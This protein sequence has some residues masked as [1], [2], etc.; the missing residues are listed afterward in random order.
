MTALT[1]NARRDSSILLYDNPTAPRSTLSPSIP[2]EPPEPLLHTEIS[3][4]DLSSN[5]GNNNTNNG[6]TTRS[7]PPPIQTTTLKS[8]QKHSPSFGFFIGSRDKSGGG[9]AESTMTDHPWIPFRS[10]Q[11]LVVECYANV[12]AVLKDVG[13]P[14][15]KLMRCMEDIKDSLLFRH[16]DI[17]AHHGA[18]IEGEPV[19]AYSMTPK[20]VRFDD[21]NYDGTTPLSPVYNRANEVATLRRGV[22]RYHEALWGLNDAAKRMRRKKGWIGASAGRKRRELVELF[23]EVQ[24][25]WSDVMMCLAI[26][27]ARDGSQV[28]VQARGSVTKLAVVTGVTA[29]DMEHSS[30]DDAKRL[31][32]QG[33]RYLFGFGVEQ[34]YDI[35]FKRFQTAAKLGL[36]EAANMLGF[37]YEH[38][39][40]KKQD[41]VE[42]LRWYTE[43]AEGCVN[44][45]TS[46]MS[47]ATHTESIDASV[48]PGSK[49]SASMSCADAWNNIG[50]I[51]E[52]GKGVKADPDRAYRAYERAADA[53]HL[54]AMTNIGVMYENG[55]GRA[56]DPVKAG[57]WYRKAAERE[58]ARAQNA[59]GSCYYRGKG[60]PMDAGKAVEWYRKAVEQGN[61]N[62]MSNL[63]ICYEEGVGVMKDYAHAK[64]LY[65]LA[66]EK[67]HPSAT[68][69]L[70]YMHLMERNYS[71]ALKCFHLALALGSAD[72]A[73]NVGS[74]YETGCSGADGFHLNKD[75][76]VAITYYSEGA[77]KGYLKAKLRLAQLYCIAPPP[78]RR[79]HLAFSLFLEAAQNP[80]NDPDAQN[81]VGRLLEMGIDPSQDQNAL[82]ELDEEEAAARVEYR[83]TKNEAE[84]VEYYRKAIRQGHAGALRRYAEMHETGIEGLVARDMQKAVKLY[85]EVSGPAD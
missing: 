66:S 83:R 43:A 1:N 44:S 51:Y 34:S 80:H 21:Q 70:G 7:P 2:E 18:V 38:G 53:G 5:G 48:T 32:F 78:N 45:P 28:A 19:S 46:G 76:H 23:G 30:V 55:V 8:P 49:F 64:H 35:A 57:E 72:A 60:V 27:I 31:H 6:N 20:S 25:S 40:G 52:S 84:A 75:V 9:N 50:R 59:L 11:E 14:S 13:D 67:L 47:S 36:P 33:D 71:R 3:V 22:W 26:C 17:V 58:Y 81:M 79:P 42:A 4:I 29:E 63:G 16:E 61:A 12:G 73:F 62:A 10:V 54:D 74:L 69:N 39:L 24:D 15:G 77:Q 85:T 56:P 37:L 41:M 68:N 82:L 65:Q